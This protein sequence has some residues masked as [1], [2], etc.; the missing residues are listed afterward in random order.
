MRTLISFLAVVGCALAACSDDKPAAVDAPTT[1]EPLAQNCTTYCSAI[2]TACTGANAQYAAAP[3]TNCSATCA[4]FPV[5]TAQDT[6]GNTL[7]CRLYHTQNV[8]KTGDAATHCPHA[9][10]AGAKVDAAAGTCG[11]ACTNF[12]ALEVKTCG[13]TDAPLTGITPQYQNAAACMTACAAF[14][15][16]TQYTAAA[17]TGDSLACRLYH[18][19][20]AALNAAKSPPDLTAASTHCGHSAATATAPCK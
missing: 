3:A 9:G 4:E 7:G 17:T 11:D 20:N 18:V 13:T 8:T 19:T 12:C 14:S 5:G 10:P 2:E 6:S 15:K 16:T 1:V